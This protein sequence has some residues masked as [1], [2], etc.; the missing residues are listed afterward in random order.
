MRYNESENKMKTI[1]LN[2]Q[3]LQLVTNAL[4]TQIKAHQEAVLIYTHDNVQD[5]AA[6]YQQDVNSQLEILKQLR[7]E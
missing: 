6:L 4:M 2:E 5:T 3:E 7:A 1:T